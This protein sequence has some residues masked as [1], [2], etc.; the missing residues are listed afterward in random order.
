MIIYNIVVYLTEHYMNQIFKTD[1]FAYMKSEFEAVSI[2]KIYFV[3]GLITSY[4][5][6][7]AAHNQSH[8]RNAQSPSSLLK[9]IQNGPR[10]VLLNR[11]RYN[12]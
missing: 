6:N 4:I 1:L 11:H 5:K 2:A 7:K 3:F 8:S 9:N 12:V 10:A